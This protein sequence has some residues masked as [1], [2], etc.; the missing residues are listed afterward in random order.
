MAKVNCEDCGKEIG[1]VQQVQLSDRRYI[2]RACRKKTIPYFEHL[3]MS[4]AEYQ[5]HLKQNEDGQKLY[6][7]YFKKNKSKKFKRMCGDHVMYD[8]ETALVCINAKRGGFLFFGGTMFYNVFRVADLDIY[9]SSSKF[10]KGQDG[11][12]VEKTSLHLTF[13]NVAGMYDYKIETTPSAIK[14]ASKVFDEVFGGKGFIGGL[15]QSFKKNQ[16]QAMA[17]AGIANGLKAAVSG[18]KDGNGEANE[19]VVAGATQV[20]ANME[21]MF[22]AGRE[23]LI[24]KADAAIK[25]VLG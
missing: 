18:M 25:N 14:G 13:R 11:K 8:P 3:E 22:Y 12:N 21:N 2:C 10:V 1:L 4:Y 6:E 15:K 5:A 23:D 9:E 19:D 17:V 16:A 7:A 24:A 20:A